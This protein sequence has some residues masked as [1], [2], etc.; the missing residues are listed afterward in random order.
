M[1]TANLQLLRS[2]MD[3]YSK[4]SEAISSN[5]ANKNTP[6]YQRITVSFEDQLREA[7]NQVPSLRNPT[8]VEAGINVEDEQ[9]VLEDEMMNLSD[10]Q[11]RMQL[12]NRGLREHFELM[13]TGITG[14]P[15]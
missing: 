6:G 3:A 10:T 5:L 8:D 2:A 12:A 14:R 1:E 11:M 15:Q 7:R 4:R 13:R 9:P